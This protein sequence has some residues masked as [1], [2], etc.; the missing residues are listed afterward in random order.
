MVASKG[1]IVRIMTVCG[2]GV[3]SSV[4]LRANI[5]DLLKKYNIKGE[6]ITADP[7]TAAGQPADI[8]VTQPVFASTLK[9]TKASEIVLLKNL[10]D[11]KEL[12]E[13]LIPVIRRLGFLE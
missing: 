10:V 8:I 3:G 13:K 7:L 11:K 1:K 6:V 2:A 9:N 12:E 4:M 5:L